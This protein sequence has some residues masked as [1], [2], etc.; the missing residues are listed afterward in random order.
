[1]EITSE[2][3][4][5]K[6]YI[7]DFIQKNNNKD[8]NQY[9]VKNSIP[10]IWF[11]D[12]EK[13][14]YSKKKII[15]IGLNPSNDEFIEDRFKIINFADRDMNKNIDSLKNTLNV[16]FHNNPYK[17]WFSRGEH[18]LNAFDASYYDKFNNTAIHIDIYTAIATNPTW[19]KLNKNIKEKL[20]RT[21][22][23]NMLLDYLNPDIILVSVNKAIFEKIFK[24]FALDDE[25]YEKEN[26]KSTFYIRKYHKDKK[27]LFWIFN[28]RGTA[29]GL[30][31]KFMDKN[32]REMLYN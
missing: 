12:I 29:F 5:I 10:V 26:N 8:L 15:T 31:Y 17:L 6:A 13:Y 3:D 30:S 21:D 1:M 7:E 20:Q 25:K 22:L 9:I 4:I 27:L 14:K 24:D 32:I 2:K 18:V 16:Y 19:G 28:N 11:G 23:F